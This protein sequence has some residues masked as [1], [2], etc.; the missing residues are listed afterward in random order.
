MSEI[1]RHLC[2]SCG[3]VLDVD[4]EKQIYTCPKPSSRK[5]DRKKRGLVY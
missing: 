1:K 2:E 4:L 3:A 5:R